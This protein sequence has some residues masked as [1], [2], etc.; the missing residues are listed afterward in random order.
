MRYTLF[1]LSLRTD[2]V[3]PLLP[4]SSDQVDVNVVLGQVHPGPSLIWAIQ[5]PMEF[6]CT[7]AGDQVVLDWPGMRFGVT[8]DRVVIDTGN[9]ACAE[10]PL[11][12]ATWSVVLTANGREALHGSVVAHN[13]RA[14]AVVGASGSGKSTAA[15]ALLDRGWELVADDMLTLDDM[16]KVMLGPPFIR[17]THERAVGRNGS[18]DTSGKLRFVPALS[19][20]PVPLGAVVVHGDTYPECQRL[21]GMAAI[22]ALLSNVYNDVLT[23]PGQAMRRLDFCARLARELPIY[24]VPPRSLSGDQLEQIAGLEMVRV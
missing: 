12:Q 5:E 3:L 18:W 23:H 1:G 19:K 20:E 10:I 21:F 24:G 6:T 14:I 7:R 4:S 15:L 9:M 8:A 16:G 13:G 2:L 17:L 22:D 11:M